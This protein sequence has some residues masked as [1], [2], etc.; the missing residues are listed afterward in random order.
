MPARDFTRRMKFVRYVTVLLA[1]MSLTG[2]I[3]G[4]HKKP[5]SPPPQVVDLS[6]SAPT[7]PA[8]TNTFRVTP[9][10]SVMGRVTLVNEKLRFV[11]VTFPLGQ[12]PPVGNRMNVFRNGAIVGE[13]KISQQQRDDNTVAD[14]VLGEAKKGD[15]IR[16]K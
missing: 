12:V 6:P 3:F 8:N 13:I 14:I 5:A 11:V 15:E 4:K 2:C 16:P 9:D 10:E 1:A 7:T